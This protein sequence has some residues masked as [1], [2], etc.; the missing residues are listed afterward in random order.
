M[1]VWANSGSWWWTGGLAC[2]G[3]WGC[4][5]LDRCEPLNWTELIHSIFYFLYFLL[6][7]VWRYDII[8][9]RSTS[10]FSVDLAYAGI[11]KHSSFNRSLL[12]FLWGW[13][14][15]LFCSYI[16]NSMV[17]LL[18]IFI[19]TYL[20]SH[21]ILNVFKGCIR[22]G[23][24]LL[25]MIYAFK[26]L[27]KVEILVTQSCLSLCNPIDC[28]LPGSSVRG[29]LQARILEWISIPLSRGSSLPRDRAWLS[30]IAGWFFKAWATREAL[31]FW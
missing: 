8:T 18:F 12:V 1:W 20:F 7:I 4:K 17:I 5:E 19:F 11:W 25:P 15:C 21:T 22:V 27:M 31:K 6:I 10:V 9:H 13:V 23:R 3:S 2:C 26:I 29:I 16:E 14:L 24:L 28:S 30:F